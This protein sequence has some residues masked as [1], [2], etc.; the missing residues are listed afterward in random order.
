MT[1]TTGTGGGGAGVTAL[2]AAGAVV[3][4]LMVVGGAAAT[5]EGFLERLEVTSAPLPAG[6]GS[7]V[8]DLDLGS[9][10]VRSASPG[11]PGRVTR[12]ARWATGQPESA[13]TTAAATTTVSG[14]CPATFSLGARCRVDVDV[15]VPAGTTVQVL[16][17]VGDVDLTDLSGRIDVATRVGDVV[18]V[19]LSSSEVSIEAVTGD[20]AVRLVAPPMR[21][22]AVTTTGDVEV[23]VPRAAAGDGYRIT[24]Q[25]PASS[26]TVGLPSD[27]AA[28]RSLTV[29]TSVGDVTIGPA[30]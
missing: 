21:V 3:A 18:A 22:R 9:V 16:T 5:V 24:V 4:L 6:T 29:A 13:V 7:L 15:E 19:G 10:T 30:A 14:R 17:G 11:S 8:V 28:S 23:T 26:S 2:R 20:V 27:P 12:W 25:A 1:G